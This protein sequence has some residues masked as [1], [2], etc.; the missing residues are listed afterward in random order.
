MIGLPCELRA[1][2]RM[3]STCPPMPADAGAPRM[4]QFLFGFRIVS[5]MLLVALTVLLGWLAKR[6]AAPQIIA[7]FRGS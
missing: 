7:E 3:K 2:P 4:D 1:A 5:G 6:L